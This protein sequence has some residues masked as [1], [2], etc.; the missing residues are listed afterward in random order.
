MIVEDDDSD[1]NEINCCYIAVFFSFCWCAGRDVRS[2]I[3]NIE[4]LINEISFY[5]RE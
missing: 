5:F 2:A 3:D 1:L 4:E